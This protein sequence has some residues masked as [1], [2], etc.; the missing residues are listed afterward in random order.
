MLLQTEFEILESRCDEE[1]QRA[2]S[3]A[4]IHTFMVNNKLD[5][6]VAR[7][8]NRVSA[9]VNFCWLRLHTI[10][11]CCPEQTE[12]IP[13]PNLSPDQHFTRTSPVWGSGNWNRKNQ[14]ERTRKKEP[15][16]SLVLSTDWWWT[17]KLWHSESCYG[18]EGAY[19]TGTWTS[20]N[21]LLIQLKI[22]SFKPKQNSFF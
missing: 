5:K 7:N 20:M 12:Q 16:C 6:K 3:F 17:S 14:K 21:P 10:Y 15:E 1:K 22:S 18:Q 8:T 13:S 11:L 2:P 9:Q 19:L 4:K